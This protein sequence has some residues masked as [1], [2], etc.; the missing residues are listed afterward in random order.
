MRPRRDL[1][2]GAPALLQLPTWRTL[3][4]PV[5]ANVFDE[6]QL[7]ASIWNDEGPF[8]EWYPIHT[9]PSILSFEY[10]L[11]A[12]DERH[13]YNRRS[14]ARAYKT[15]R[16]VHGQHA[17][18]DDFFVPISDD[19]GVRAILVVGS[20]ATSRP[21]A[22]D[23]RSRWHRLS[24]SP[25]K[26]G[27]PAFLGYAAATLA[28]T[29]F[30]GPLL[31][32]F[33]TFVECYAEL[34]AGRGS[35]TELASR[36]A[37][38][39]TRL[40]GTRTARDMWS[41]VATMVD[42]RT[43]SSWVLRVKQLRPSGLEQLPRHVL[44]GLTVSR[45]PKSDPIDELVRRDAFQRSAVAYATKVGRLVCGRV[46]DHGVVALLDSPVAGAREKVAALAE[47]LGGLARRFGFTLHSGAN[48]GKA[49]ADLPAQYDRALHT[50]E[51]AVAEGTALLYADVPRP[52]ADSAFRVLCGQHQAL[53]RVA[54]EHPDRLMADYDRYARTV[55][56][57]C[58]HRVER[59]RGHL[60]AGLERMVEPLLASGAVEAPSIDELAATL[61]AHALGASTPSAL[62][63]AFRAFVADL[64]RA[65][66]A[67]TS[68]PQE[69]RVR[70]A[71]AYVQEHLEDHLALATV[72]RVAHFAPGY[73][74]KLV[75]RTHGMS[76]EAYVQRARVERAKRLL[77]ST[78]VKIEQ[79]GQLCGFS[80]R[81]Y[82][83]HVFKQAVGVTPGAYR[84][85]GRT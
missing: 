20:F 8:E 39:R 66:A 70:R 81:H 34:L 4:A 15:R 26:S 47:R 21:S 28:T 43:A 7:G 25:G 29:T 84:I 12:Q 67:P 57:H 16:T 5:L 1:V 40:A 9:P 10:E 42:P 46:G 85:A 44:V 33:R 36:A 63:D 68:A 49:R 52:A 31:A 60:E 59:A 38:L 69:R 32:V 78:S 73:F 35:P 71:L 56:R 72:A 13:R 30:E 82:F 58:G 3:L 77:S 79:I 83:H 55:F 41:L 53:G 17:G 23:V 45:D 64:Q 65:V 54:R 24:G 48:I 19:G 27:D 80:N 75:R 18:F 74:S 61:E 51:A 37:D 11:G 50:G 76:F 2:S 6:L 22:A 62:E 14:F